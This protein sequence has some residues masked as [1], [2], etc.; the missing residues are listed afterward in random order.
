MRSH[1]SRLALTA[2]VVLVVL[3]ATFWLSFALIIATLAPDEA[4]RSYCQ[5]TP[6]FVPLNVLAVV[7]ALATLAVLVTAA[8]FAYGAPGRPLG[9]SLAIGLV[10]FA[11][12]TAYDGFGVAGCALGV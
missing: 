5:G 4:V 7:G 6:A 11:A 12:W 9:V 1:R 8:R 3:G 10:A 2:L